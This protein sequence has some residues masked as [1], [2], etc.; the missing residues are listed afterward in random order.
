MLILMLM[1]TMVMKLRGIG[2]WDDG[3]SEIFD[4]LERMG[5]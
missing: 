2:D 3:V 1:R 5:V 4:E